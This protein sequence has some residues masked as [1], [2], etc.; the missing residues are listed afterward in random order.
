MIKSRFKL[1]YE[2]LYSIAIVAGAI[3]YCLV[4]IA[5]VASPAIYLGYKIISR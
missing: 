4:V 2:R 1:F 5:V 3:G